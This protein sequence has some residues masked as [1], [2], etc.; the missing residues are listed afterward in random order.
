MNE[1][2]PLLMNGIILAGDY[3]VALRVDERSGYGK[4]GQS[5]CVCV[6]TKKALVIAIY[7]DSQTPGKAVSRVEKLADYLIGLSPLI[8]FISLDPLF[9]NCS[10]LRHR[11]RLLTTRSS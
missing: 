7:G 5:G 11:N 10:H 6:K 8:W 3:F 9:A 2:S 1:D 4:K